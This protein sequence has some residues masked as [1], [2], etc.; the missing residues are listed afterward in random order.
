MPLTTA[1]I[2]AKIGVVEG[3]PL[4]L[5]AHIL[6]EDA[7]I[8]GYGA[9][10]PPCVDGDEEVATEHDRVLYAFTSLEKAE[11]FAEEISWPDHD[12]PYPRVVFAWS[13]WG[14][15]PDEGPCYAKPKEANLRDIAYAVAYYSPR[16]HTLAIDAGPYGEGRYIPLEDLGWSRELVEVYRAVPAATHIDRF[17]RETAE[18]AERAFREGRAVDNHSLLRF[19]VHRFKSLYE[20]PSRGEGSA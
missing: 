14:G 6:D 4:Y 1:E 15:L 19:P 11:E 13:D 12:P 2:Y 8:Q 7:V 20:D 9:T 18:E 10:L 17:F 3:Q 16:P 5:L